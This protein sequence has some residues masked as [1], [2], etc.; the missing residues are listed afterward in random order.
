MNFT[1]WYQRIQALPPL[2]AC[3]QYKRATLNSF[4]LH[5]PQNFHYYGGYELSLSTKRTRN[6]AKSWCTI[7]CNKI[8][9]VKFNLWHRNYS[10]SSNL[11]QT[12]YHFIMITIIVGAR[13][14]QTRAFA[15]PR[16][17]IFH[18]ARS[19]FSFVFSFLLSFSFAFQVNNFSES[20][21][22]RLQ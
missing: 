18:L 11:L 7:Q 12:T 6:D 15:A 10:T 5:F 21:H 13:K 3:T 14:L 2:A 17:N 19:S 4:R 1:N 22:I 20:A 16:L 8:K 9:Q